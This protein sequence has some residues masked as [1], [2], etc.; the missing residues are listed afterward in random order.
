FVSI[1]L[2]VAVAMFIGLLGS[3]A[4]A[5]LGGLAFLYVQNIPYVRSLTFVL[6]WVALGFLVGLAVSLFDVLAGLARKDVR[7]PLT[8]LVK[9]TLGGTLGGILGGVFALALRSGGE[10]IGTAADLWT[11]TA[12]GFVILGGLIGLLVGLSQII[13]LEAWIKVEAGFRPG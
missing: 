10:L 4:C 11:P 3:S 13:L 7:G 1:F 2:R 12:V 9:C 5:G 8:K 6:I